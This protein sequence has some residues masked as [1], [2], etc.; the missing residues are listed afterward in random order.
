MQN[1]YNLLVR[2][3]EDEVLPACERL[4]IGFV[5]F[6]P[7]ASGLLTGKYTP[8]TGRGPRARG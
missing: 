5:P 7:L 3:A 4:G 8:P 1:E 6:F 2:D